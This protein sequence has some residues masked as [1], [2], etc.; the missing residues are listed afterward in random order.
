V[1]KRRW[2]SLARTNKNHENLKNVKN[3]ISSRLNCNLRTGTFV[4]HLL[5]ALLFLV[6][7]S[8]LTAKLEV[9]PA[10]GSE[11]IQQAL[12]QLGAGG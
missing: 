12:D 5:F 9:L 8:G 6:P 3:D 1:F 7:F 4:P 10:A 2:E 11:G